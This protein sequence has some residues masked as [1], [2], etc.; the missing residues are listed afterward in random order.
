MPGG[1]EARVTGTGRTL[2]AIRRMI[3]AHARFVNGHDGLSVTVSALAGPP[4]EGLAVTVTTAEAQAVDRVK[5]LGF[6]GFLVA[7][8][9]HLPH[10]SAMALGA[11]HP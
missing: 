8:D 10:H 4:D 11:G 2:D 5:G 9:H 3:P 1:F 7:G 6:F